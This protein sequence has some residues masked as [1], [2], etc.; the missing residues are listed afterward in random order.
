[1]IM[2]KKSLITYNKARMTDY[3]R[4]KDSQQPLSP[5][6]LLF[7]IHL[8]EV[9]CHRFQSKLQTNPFHPTQAHTA[10]RT[11]RLNLSEHCLR[12]YRTFA[13]V[14]QPLLAQQQFTCLRLVVIE[15]VIHLYPPIPLR[16]EALTAQRKTLAIHCLI[17]THRTRKTTLAHPLSPTAHDNSPTSG[18][19][20]PPLASTDASPLCSLSA[21]RLR[22]LARGID[23][24]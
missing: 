15:F 14:H 2:Y 4:A 19:L 12:L 23:I 18:G 8:L 11:I 16:L 9:M 13:P 21:R 3:I 6:L 17:D 22:Y 1:M 5:R 20:S 7:S 10:K 24:A